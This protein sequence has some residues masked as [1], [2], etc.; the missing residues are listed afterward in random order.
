MRS[1][2]FMLGALALAS[3]T[4]LAAHAQTIAP[5]SDSI[6]AKQF[7]VATALALASVP[8]LRVAINRHTP[9]PTH[10]KRLPGFPIEGLAA[11]ALAT[12]AKKATRRTA[13]KRSSV[14]LFL[15]SHVDVVR[16]EDKEGRPR[17]ERIAGGVLVDDTDL[18]DDEIDELTALKAIRPATPKEIEQLDRNEVEEKRAALVREQEEEMAAL[19][20]EHE[21]AKADLGTDASPAKVTKLEEKQAAEVSK[22]QDKHTKALNKV[23]E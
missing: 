23:A 19:R 15:D 8:V 11:A 17:V 7:P 3:A 2:R 22:L 9:A 10:H 20:A 4:G 18:T 13:G 21:Q 1:L 16:G 6:S 5:A 14:K 12:K